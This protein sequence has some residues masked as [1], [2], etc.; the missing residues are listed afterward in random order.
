MA[1]NISNIGDVLKRQIYLQRPAEYEGKARKVYAGHAIRTL[2]AHLDAGPGPGPNFSN[3]HRRD[4][5]VFIVSHWIG[6]FP[7]S[8]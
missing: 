4:Y 3:S 8:Y 5:D 7:A 1:G 6:C 2:P